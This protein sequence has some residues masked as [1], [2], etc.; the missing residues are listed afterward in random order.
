LYERPPGVP[1]RPISVV[2]RGQ[3]HVEYSHVVEIRDDVLLRS[4][5][6]VYY[7]IGGILPGHPAGHHEG[8]T[9]C[10]VGLVPVSG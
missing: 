7:Y 5:L 8:T 2:A 1:R 3:N 9:R 6:V 4:S 10:G